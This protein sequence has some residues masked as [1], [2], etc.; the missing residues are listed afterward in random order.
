MSGE[1]DVQSVSVAADGTLTIELEQMWGNG[2]GTTSAV[3][4]SP[5]MLDALDTMVE[6]ARKVVSLED[7]GIHP[8][9]E[10]T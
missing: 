3:R 2:G 5:C 9:E 7:R 10:Q 6:R 1:W 4:I 8:K